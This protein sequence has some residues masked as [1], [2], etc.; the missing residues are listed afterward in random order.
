MRLSWSKNE[1]GAIQSE[2]AEK[3][4]RSWK[5]ANAP[6]H[7]EGVKLN[8]RG[9]R[10]RKGNEEIVLLAGSYVRER[11]RLSRGHRARA[12]EHNKHG[13]GVAR[14]ALTLATVLS[15]FGALTRGLRARVR[16]L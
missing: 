8:S 10:P 4:M 9:Q 3:G 16:I 15:P 11:A 1:I 6:H 13:P 12:V 14:V 2:I 5:A 7:A